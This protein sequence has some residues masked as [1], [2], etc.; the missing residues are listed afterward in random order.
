MDGLGTYVRANGDIF[1]GHFTKGKLEGPGYIRYGSGDFYF[2]CF[3]NHQFDGKGLFKW[4][5]GRLYIGEY[6]Q[7]QQLSYTLTGSDGQYQFNDFGTTFPPNAPF[8]EDQMAVTA[9]GKMGRYTGY[10][11]AHTLL[12][13]GMGRMVE[14]DRSMEYH[15]TWFEG[16][17]DGLGISTRSNGKT[18]VGNFKKDT[19]EG[20]GFSTNGY[21][22]SSTSLESGMIYF[23]N[24]KGSKCEGRGFIKWKGG[25]IYVGEFQG[26]QRSFGFGNRITGD[27]GRYLQQKSHVGGMDV[28][29]FA[30][31][32]MASQSAIFSE[33]TGF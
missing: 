33:I 4:K 18:Y 3:A 15:G 28:D 31:S 5:D 21:G 7:G 20:Y 30:M 26:G 27:D 17:K 2:G 22:Y 25:G 19:F 1:V 12:P 10:V 13:H 16:E 29:S 23:G 32:S 14:K 8:V 6:R 24:F 9:S 11:S